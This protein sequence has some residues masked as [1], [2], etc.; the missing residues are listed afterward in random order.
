MDERQFYRVALRELDVEVGLRAG[1]QT[2]DGEVLDLSIKGVGVLFAQPDAP[3]LAV[4]DSVKLDFRSAKVRA[5]VRLAS[6]V[7]HR[8]DM[9]L[10]RRYGFAFDSLDAAA[11]QLSELLYPLF[12]RRRVPRV[13]PHPD[14]PLEVTLTTSAGKRIEAPLRHLSAR[15]MAVLVSVGLEASLV[16]IE[17]VVVSFQLPRGRGAIELVAWIRSRLL[18][19]DH[20]IYGMEFDP[21]RSERFAQSEMELVDYVMRRQRQEPG[22]WEG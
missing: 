15:G 3:T 10:F 22:R 12:N 9:N 21:E 1:E 8:Q 19:D 6:T 2:F 16:E 20:V 4:G 18:E 13:D 5:S 17:E 14:E 7:R 11:E